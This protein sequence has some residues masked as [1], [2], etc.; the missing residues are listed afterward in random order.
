MVKVC[1]EPV[2]VTPPPVYWGIIVIVATTGLALL[3]IAV[4]AGM[5][6]PL[7]VAARPILVLLF[8]HV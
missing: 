5:P 7:P 8:A 2:Q 1:D 3:F 4:N 6:V